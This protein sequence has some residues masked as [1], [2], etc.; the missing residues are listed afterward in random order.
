MSK[1]SIL[2]Q[3]QQISYYAQDVDFD[4]LAN[5]DADWAS[6]SKAAK[7]SK[8]VDFQDPKVVL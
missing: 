7:A 5:R 6:I 3:Q 1:S 4:D 8:W 2:H